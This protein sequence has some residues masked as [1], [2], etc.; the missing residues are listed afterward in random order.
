MR[1][2]T[3]VADDGRNQPFSPQY[4]LDHLFA[5]IFGQPAG[6]HQEINRRADD[7]PPYCGR[8]DS[9]GSCLQKELEKAVSQFTIPSLGYS[10][11]NETVA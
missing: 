8:Q 9:K 7:L 2:R 6:L 4:P 5:L 10:Q 11:L 1:D 3:S